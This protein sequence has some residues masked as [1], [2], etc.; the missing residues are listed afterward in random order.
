MQ[1]QAFT[2]HHLTFVVFCAAA[3]LL[4]CARPSQAASPKVELIR[5]N[6]GKA[7]TAHIHTYDGK[8]Y[9]SGV[10][11]R[12]TNWMGPHVHIVLVDRNGRVIA[13]ETTRLTG[14]HGK[15][16]FN[17]RGTYTASFAPEEVARA[18]AV[19][20]TF[21]GGLHAYCNKATSNRSES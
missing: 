11:Y 10:V 17:Q 7:A 5:T 4:A 19:Q 15:P 9:I 18:A 8:T 1:T 6:A 14:W 16:S 21:L 2:Y 12:R 13:S 3:I 20:I